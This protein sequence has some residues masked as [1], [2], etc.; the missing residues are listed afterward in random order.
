MK[1]SYPLWLEIALKELG[2]KEISGSMQNNPRILEYHLTTKLK[3][4]QDEVPWCSSFVNWVMTQCGISGT[5]SA[6]ASSWGTWGNKCD[7]SLGAI[8]LLKFDNNAS[9][10]HVGFLIWSDPTKL[11]VLGGN[12]KDQVNITSYNPNRLLGF[13]WPSVWMTGIP[14][15]DSGRKVV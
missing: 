15:S 14:V 5:D 6:A 7:A 8:T 9:G 4:S 3:A 11:L 1:Q 13:R 2:V 10:H 12:Q